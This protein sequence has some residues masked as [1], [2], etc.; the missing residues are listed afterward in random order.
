MIDDRI[1]HISHE[2]ESNEC[3]QDPSSTYN[4]HQRISNEHPVRL[5][6]PLGGAGGGPKPYL[7]RNL[8]FSSFP[9]QLLIKCLVLITI[10]IWFGTSPNPSKGGECLT[11]SRGTIWAKAEVIDDRINHISHESES[12]ECSQDPSSTYNFHQRISNEHPVRLS[13]PLG[14]AGGGPKPYL[15]R[16]LTFSSFPTQLLIKCLVLITIQSHTW[17]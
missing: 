5:S 4:F 10:K 15:N 12:N 1:N 17:L 11:D 6:P 3:S 2:S 7:N 16:N 9:T 14:G 8:T 13:P